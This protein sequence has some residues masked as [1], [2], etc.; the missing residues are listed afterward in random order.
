MVQRLLDAQTN[1]ANQL[2][3]RLP[4]KSQTHPFPA[5]TESISFSAVPTASFRSSHTDTSRAITEPITATEP[6]DTFLIRR[7][8]FGFQGSFASHYDYAVLIDAAAKS[9]A[10]RL[11]YTFLS[12]FL[13]TSHSTRTRDS[14][15]SL[16][17]DCGARV[18]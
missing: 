17:F 3:I 2:R 13:K 11:S 16:S 8:R 4:P 14:N 7:A 15:S 5:G 18:I 9:S 6:P 1:P 12:L 10:R